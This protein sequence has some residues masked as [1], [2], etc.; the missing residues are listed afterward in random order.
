M[1]RAPRPAD[2]PR[3]TTVARGART[4]RHPH[5]EASENW[6]RGFLHPTLLHAAA[7]SLFVLN[8]RYVCCFSSLLQ[9]TFSLPAFNRTACRRCMPSPLSRH[10]HATIRMYTNMVII[11][12]TCIYV[13]I[14]HTMYV[15]ISQARDPG[16][17]ELRAGSGPEPPIISYCIIGHS[18]V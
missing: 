16:V 3:P 15:C 9:I 7:F 12:C 18:I 11:T 8:V 2:T 13:Y 6:S 10:A 1:R 14:V 4:P 17:V 5:L